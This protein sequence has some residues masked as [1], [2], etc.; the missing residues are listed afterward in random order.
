[1]KLNKKF[2]IVFLV[3]FYLLVIQRIITL[4]LFPDLGVTP[5]NQLQQETISYLMIIKIVLLLIALSM[6]SVFMVLKN[7]SGTND[8]PISKEM[9]FI[10]ILLMSVIIP[11]TALLNIFLTGDLL[12]SS[13]LIIYGVVFT[14]TI[15]AMDY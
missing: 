8:L 12:F 6:I 1:M 13:I 11:I 3:L 15:Y 7:N 9:F 4:Y 10:L 2:I 14:I 5:I